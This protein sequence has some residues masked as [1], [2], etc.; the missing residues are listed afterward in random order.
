[1]AKKDKGLTG[2]ELSGFCGQVGIILNA[3]IPLYDGMETL[4]E[5]AAADTHGALYAELSRR[6]NETGSLYEAMKDD[7]R[8]PAYLREMVGI[9]ERSGQL[10]HVMEGLKQHYAREERVRR[11]VVNAV[12]YPLSL[13]VMLVVIVFI[14]LVRVLPVFRRVLSSMGTGAGASGSALISLG[15]ALAWVVLVLVGLALLFVIVL[16]ALM[17]TRHRHKTIRFL[18][19]H[20]PPVRRLLDK[21]SASRAAGILSMMLGS[22]FPLEEA[23]AM[24]EGAIADE[25]AAGKVQGIREALE[26]GDSFADAI[27]QAK[28]FDELQNRMVRVGVAAGREDQVMAEIAQQTEEEAEEGIARLVGIIEPT[29]VALLSVVIGAILLAVMLPMAGILSSMM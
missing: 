3:G 28:L 2:A 5:S 29:L 13:G 19:R 12:T 1:M 14:M 11:T 9:G 24:T 10:E 23:L 6:V 20:F 4:A 16:A 25:T 15:T 7:A 18:I 27:A 17:R 8:W 26:R 22:G 21:L